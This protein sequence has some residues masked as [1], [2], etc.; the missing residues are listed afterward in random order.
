MRKQSLVQIAPKVYYYGSGSVSSSSSGYQ[1]QS[2]DWPS[3]SS[4][5]MRP[6]ASNPVVEPKPQTKT[7]GSRKSLAPDGTAWSDWD[8]HDQIWKT[9]KLIELGITKPGTQSRTMDETVAE[10]I[11]DPHYME[12]LEEDL[13]ELLE[14]E[15]ARPREEKAPPK[16]QTQT[17]RALPAG[18]RRQSFGIFCSGKGSDCCDA[19]Q[20]VAPNGE[21]YCD[22]CMLNKS[23]EKGG[24]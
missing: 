12:K 6:R 17:D 24:S 7:N 14:P 8:A 20:N 5:S 21:V 23:N 9:A 22:T 3:S 11:N 4:V 19:A 10:R 18:W 2:D 16:P 1:S 13:R 15:S